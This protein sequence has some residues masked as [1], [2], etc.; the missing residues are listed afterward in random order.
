MVSVTISIGS[1]CGD[2]NSLIEEAIN[3]L[4]KI[5]MQTKCSAVY[6]TPCALKAGK[7]YLNAVLRGF[8]PGDGIELESL[9]KEKEK[10]MGR[11]SKC[12]ERGDVPIDMDI[13]ICAGDIVK[14]WDYRQKFFQIG[15]KE[16]EGEGNTK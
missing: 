9:L 11:D 4:E 7:P 15:F 3:W 13:V 10:N 2:R 6:E 8:Y 12:R 5:L 1:N 16:I 14:E